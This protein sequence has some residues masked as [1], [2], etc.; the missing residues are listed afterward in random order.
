[1]TEI[2]EAQS[3]PSSLGALNEDSRGADYE[4][5][6]ERLIKEYDSLPPQ[7]KAGVLEKARM[8]YPVKTAAFS[9][10]GL[11]EHPHLSPI[12]KLVFISR[13]PGTSTAKIGALD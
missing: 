5:F 11:A 6:T 8:K 12:Q 7:K 1:L 2:E 10:D 9:S 13:A 3:Q 4:F